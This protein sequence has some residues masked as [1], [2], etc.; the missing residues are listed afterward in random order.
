MIMDIFRNKDLNYIGLQFSRILMPVPSA[1][2]MV[3]F[4]HNKSA[5]E[6]SLKPKTSRNNNVIY[7]GRFPGN[8]AHQPP[9]LTR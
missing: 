5:Q 6:E 9:K 8:P 2:L 3:N 1:L 7:T 4:A